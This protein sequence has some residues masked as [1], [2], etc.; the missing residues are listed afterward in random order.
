[1]GNEFLTSLINISWCG[2]KFCWMKSVK[3]AGWGS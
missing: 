2:G 3:G 1:M